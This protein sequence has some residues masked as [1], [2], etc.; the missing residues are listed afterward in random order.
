MKKLTRFGKDGR[1]TAPMLSDYL[2]QAGILTADEADIPDLEPIQDDLLHYL[3]RIAYLEQAAT[4]E[5]LP[6]SQDSLDAFIQFI[7]YTQPNGRGALAISPDG[8]ATI[9]WEW[10]HGSVQLEFKKS[11]TM[12]CYCHNGDQHLVESF[13]AFEEAVRFVKSA[14]FDGILY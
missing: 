11:A 3:N 8:Y 13:T 9:Y 5:Q 4:E 14:G 10:Q 7:I 6:L 1:F 2:A 12:E